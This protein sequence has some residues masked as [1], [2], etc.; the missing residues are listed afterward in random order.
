MIEAAGALDKTGPGQMMGGQDPANLGGRA[1]GHME[2]T[3]L[4]LSHLSPSQEHFH[5]DL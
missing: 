4:V 1:Q 3:K 2:L 5:Y